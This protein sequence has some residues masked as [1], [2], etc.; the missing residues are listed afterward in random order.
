MFSPRL[1]DRCGLIMGNTQRAFHLA[2]VLCF[3]KT[4]LFAFKTPLSLLS[5]LIRMYLSVNLVKLTKL[6]YIILEQQT[7]LNLNFLTH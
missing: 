2:R 1:I 7:T 5:P 6:F 3:Q 4:H